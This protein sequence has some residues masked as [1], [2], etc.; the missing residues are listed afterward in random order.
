MSAP[1]DQSR[2]QFIS[3]LHAETSQL[4]RDEIRLVHEEFREAARYAAIGVGVSAVADMFVALGAVAMVVAAIAAL[5]LVMSTWAAALIVGL[6]L[7]SGAGVVLLLNRL[8]IRQAIPKAAKPT[9]EPEIRDITEIPLWW[10]VN[11]RYASPPH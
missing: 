6:A 8:Q 2:D 3:Q 10:N 7:W 1:A 5:A 11:N 9:P 4:V